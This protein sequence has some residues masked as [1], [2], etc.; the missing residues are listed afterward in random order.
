M[1]VFMWNLASLSHKAVMLISSF[2]SRWSCL[3]QLKLGLF[4]LT[5]PLSILSAKLIIH[6]QII[7]KSETRL[8]NCNNTWKHQ[9]YGDW[10]DLQTA[11]PFSSGGLVTTSD[12]D[13]LKPTRGRAGKE[14]PWQP[15][16]R[17]GGCHRRAREGTSGAL[18]R[19]W[20]PSGRRACV[21]FEV[22]PE[23]RSESFLREGLLVKHLHWRMNTLC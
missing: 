17:A 2:G 5:S 22:N 18:G 14:G 11:G 23:E 13:G 3:G 15:Q 10:S 19:P 8:L 21:S 20:R 9:T 1:H 6:G 4:Q 12:G 16:R 7:N